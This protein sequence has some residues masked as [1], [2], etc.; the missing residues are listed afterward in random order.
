MQVDPALEQHLAEL[1]TYLLQLDVRQSTDEVLKLLADEFIEFGSSGRIFTK[2]EINVA[3]Q[4][5]SPT[6]RTR[7]DFKA[8]ELAQDV[9]L[10]TYRVT[11]IETP[12]PKT[13]RTLRSSIWKL[14]DGRWQ[15][16]FPQG[17]ITQD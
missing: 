7:S 9:I 13:A 15:M 6:F 5:E 10:V 16:I 4:D 11:R 3:L 2:Q 1:E 12:P 17:T 14:I 8:T